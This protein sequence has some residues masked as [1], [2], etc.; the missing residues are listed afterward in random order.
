MNRS[1]LVLKRENPK[2]RFVTE[3]GVK[4]ILEECGVDVEINDINNY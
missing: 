2:N 1:R 3:K 4:K